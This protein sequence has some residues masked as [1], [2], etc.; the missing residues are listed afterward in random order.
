MTDGL[1]R[2]DVLLS[3]LTVGSATTAGCTETGLFGSEQSV[4]GTIHAPSR[5][6]IGD[7]FRVRLT[8][9][10]SNSQVVL[11][12]RATD[13][14]DTAFS[15]HQQVRTNGNGAATIAAFTPASDQHQQLVCVETG[16]GLGTGERSR[17]RQK[18]SI[19]LRSLTP[20]SGETTEGDTLAQPGTQTSSQFVTGR[21]SAVDLDLVVHEPGS[22]R[23]LATTTITR[24]VISDEVEYETVDTD[25]LEGWLY[26][27][28]D[29][30]LGPHSGV[31]ML[32]GSAARVPQTL[33]RMLATHGYAVLALQYFGAADLPA[34]L[35]AI[36]LEYFD[37]AVE[38]LLNRENVG[39]DAVGLVGLSRGVEPAL[40]TAANFSGRAVVVGYSG[41][42]VVASGYSQSGGVESY[43][44]A[45]TRNGSP[46]V[47]ADPIRTVFNAVASVY[48]DGC[49]PIERVP[50]WIRSRVPTALHKA[51]IPVE[52][53][54]GPV[55][56]LSGTDDQ[57]WR[58]P[59]LSALGIDR[60]SRHDAETG[61]HGFEHRSFRGAGHGF[62]FPYQDYSGASTSSDYG[63]T[64]TANER[65]A[66]AAWE[67]VL[68][69]LA[70]GL[71]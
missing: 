13:A 39:D 53:I 24:I 9:F 62:S 25:G 70:M 38:W 69:Y 55:A 23:E 52:N 66:S 28:P 16:P 5:G 34:E 41:S 17:P 47:A 45:W 71:S 20:A 30:G 54:N 36:P 40:L 4:S 61:S 32:H 12:L 42:G 58:A 37:R 3:T 22:Q 64:P 14:H 1:S 67:L 56:L 68:A 59:A 26:T 2:R 48:Q 35:D 33:S 60:L 43:E 27:P 15:A 65:A 11:T 49:D 7:S 8:G 19:S 57:L 21:Q 6:A 46:I 29:S 63:G 10:E 44:A 18:P 51:V 31:L 50:E